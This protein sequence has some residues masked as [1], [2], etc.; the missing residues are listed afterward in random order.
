MAKKTTYTVKYRRIREGKTNYKKRLQLLLSEQQ[1]VVI[2][3]SLK[4]VQIQIISYFPKGDKIDICINS[5]VLA[6]Y[7]WLGAYNNV[8]AAYLTGMLAAKK[9]LEKSIKSCI[10]DIG[11]VS[12]VKGSVVFAALAG[13]IDGGLSV[14]VNKKVFP[15]E[16]CITGKHIA[17]YAKELKLKNEEKYKKQ[18]SQYLKNGCI[19]EELP[20]MF[21]SVKA[22]IQGVKHG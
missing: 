14:P 6:K 11:N 19:P 3:R 17:N 10:C 12:P 22:K 4:A 5:R 7:G 1:R 2:R 18:F 21:L 15:N 9:A 16:E 8:P 13:V 20:N